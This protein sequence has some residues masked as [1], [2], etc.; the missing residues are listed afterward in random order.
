MDGERRQRFLAAGGAL[1][2]ARGFMALLGF[3]PP[4]VPDLLDPG[5]DD[6]Q[7]LEGLDRFLVEAK[8]EQLAPVPHFRRIALNLPQNVLCGLRGEIHRSIAN[9]YLRCPRRSWATSGLW[10][11]LCNSIS[12]EHNSVRI[13][14]SLNQELL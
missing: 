12:H 5:D 14:F 13:K 1:F 11:I 2:L 10:L 6:L 4:L 9:L 8:N 3:L 7:G